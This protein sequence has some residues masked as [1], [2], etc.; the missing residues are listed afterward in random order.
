MLEIFKKKKSLLNS[1]LDQDPKPT[2]SDPTFPHQIQV[3][4]FSTGI[5]DSEVLDEFDELYSGGGASE[6]GWLSARFHAL[7]ARLVRGKSIYIYDRRKKIQT[8]MR[9][10][11]EFNTW[12]E[13]HYPVCWND[14]E[15]SKYLS[16]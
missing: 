2:K 11:M 7:R 12:I 13:S 8:E 5:V 6:I 14:Y 15:S 3:R 1:D 16:D 9:Y 10:T 4:L